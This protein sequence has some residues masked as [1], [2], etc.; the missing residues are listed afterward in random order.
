MYKYMYV[1]IYIYIYTHVYIHTYTYRYIGFTAAYP[2]TT[3]PCATPGSHHAE[4]PKT[5]NANQ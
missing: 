3:A 1:Y 2:I 5:T 4:M